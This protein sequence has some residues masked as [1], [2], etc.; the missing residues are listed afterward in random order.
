MEDFFTVF[1]DKPTISHKGGEVVTKEDFQGTISFKNVHL[2]YKNPGKDDVKVLKNLSFDIKAGENVAF[3]GKSN[4]GK[5]TIVRALM[6]LYDVDE[7]E[8]LIDGKNMKNLNL[9]SLH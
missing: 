3:V 4:C 5:T 9:P 8:V 2:G 7:G 1:K 6:R